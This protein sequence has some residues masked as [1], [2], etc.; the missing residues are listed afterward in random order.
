MPDDNPP[1]GLTA[2]CMLAIDLTCI[3]E[4]SRQKPILFY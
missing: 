2:E 4:K 3:A 1:P